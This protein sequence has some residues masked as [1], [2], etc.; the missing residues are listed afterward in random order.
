MKCLILAGGPGVRTYPVTKETAKALFPVRG[1]PA[2]SHIVNKVQ[3]TEK[4]DEVFVI[5]NQRFYPDFEEWLDGFAAEVPIKILNDGSVNCKD[6]IGAL[7]SLNFAIDSCSLDEDLLVIGGDNLFSFGLDEF[8]ESSLA[9]K[10]QPSIGVFNLNGKTKPKKFGVVILGTERKVIDFY[11]KPPQ[12]NGSCLISLCLYFLPKE[13]L[14]L[15]KDYLAL[16]GNNGSIGNY[17]KWL[18]KQRQVRAFN[19]EGEW[20]GIGDVDSYADAVCLL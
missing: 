2:I 14:H 11:E 5:S 16:Y 12:L 18:I 13:T 17:I 4:V 20:F 15:I 8:I 1:R 10:P 19:F 6:S 3:S 9:V 7:K